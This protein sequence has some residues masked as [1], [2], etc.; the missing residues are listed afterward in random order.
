MDIIIIAGMH[1][2]STSLI[3]Q[4]L[5][6]CGLFLGANLIGP[7]NDNKDGYYE[8][9]T[10]VEC[11]NNIIKK[12]GYNIFNSKVF[13]QF[14]IEDAIAIKKELDRLVLDSKAPVIGIKDPRNVL[15]LNAW[16]DLN[17]SFKYILIF[18]NYKEVID[19]LIRRKSD[20]EIRKSPFIAAKSWINYNTQLLDF[21]YKHQEQCIFIKN[22]TI[23]EDSEVI[24]D[25]INNKLS[26]ELAHFDIM[27]VYKSY[28]IKRKKPL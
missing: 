13:S 26:I 27:K 1:R 9:R 11:Q 15:F 17:P 14:D 18:R 8:N 16:Y 23:I 25:H 5:Q 20:H 6:R 28:L 19:S 2:S 7:A 21:Y 12:H 4:Y 3:T 22:D 24:I 10:I